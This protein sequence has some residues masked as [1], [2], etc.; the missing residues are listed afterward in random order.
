[1][2]YKNTFKKMNEKLVNFEEQYKQFEEKLKLIKEQFLNN[3]KQNSNY[4]NLEHRIKDL[5]KMFYINEK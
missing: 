2:K 5:E 1:M 3:N 4:M